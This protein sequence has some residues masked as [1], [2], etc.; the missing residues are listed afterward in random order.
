MVDHRGPWFRF[1]VGAAT[2]RRVRES[3]GRGGGGVLSSR[4]LVCFGGGGARLVPRGLRLCSSSASHER[5]RRLASSF[6]PAPSNPRL[7]AATTALASAAERRRGALPWRVEAGGPLGFRGSF[8]GAAQTR[9]HPRA[10]VPSD[11]AIARRR[12]CTPHG[13]NIPKSGT[14]PRAPAR[15]R[16]AHFMLRVECMHHRTTTKI[17]TSTTTKVTGCFDEHP[18]GCMGVH[19]GVRPHH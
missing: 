7:L 8:R 3:G 15:H 14:E 10:S 11:R 5:R 4:P 12:M 18:H 13:A 17:K 9:A 16:S 1:G 6:K 19:V 2:R